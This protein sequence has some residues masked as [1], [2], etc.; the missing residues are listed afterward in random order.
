[1]AL[2]ERAR[3]GHPSE[4]QRAFHSGPIDGWRIK[5]PWN[6]LHTYKHCQEAKMAVFDAASDLVTG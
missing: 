5:D 4:G 6:T 2:E 3:D 1:L